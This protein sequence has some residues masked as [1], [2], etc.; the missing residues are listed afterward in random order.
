M[1]DTRALIRRCA[2]GVTVALITF[3]YGAAAGAVLG[4]NERPIKHWLESQGRAVL[5]ST[6]AG[7]EQRLLQARDSGWVFLRRSHLH[8]EGMATGALVLTAVLAAAGAPARCLRLASLGLGLGSAG[9]AAALILAGLR[10]PG[11]GDPALAKESLKWLAMPAG[12]L[13]IAS[14]AL[15]LA[16]FLYAARA[17]AAPAARAIA[18]VKPRRAAD[19]ELTPAVAD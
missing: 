5:A 6:Y 2:I 17:S 16:G 13:Y 15:A 3:L 19:L 4:V 12:G 18:E 8:A 14:I 1:N 10:T 11:L 9:Y 7:N